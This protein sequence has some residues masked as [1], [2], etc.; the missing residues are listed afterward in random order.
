VYGYKPIHFVE[1]LTRKGGPFGVFDTYVLEVLAGQ[2]YAR[3]AKGA[4]A[5]A[6][7]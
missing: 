2:A 5:P 7:A 6:G 3:I 1:G 4:D